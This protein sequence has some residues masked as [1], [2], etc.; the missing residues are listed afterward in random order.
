MQLQRLPSRDTLKRLP[1]CAS[2]GPRSKRMEVAATYSGAQAIAQQQN[3]GYQMPLNP[4]METRSHVADNIADVEGQSSV[5]Q[6]MKE[7]CGFYYCLN[8]DCK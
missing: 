6:L 1:G 2:R 3:N 5:D 7:V 4:I 8:M